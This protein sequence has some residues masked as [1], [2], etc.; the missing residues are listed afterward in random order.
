M[1]VDAS[2]GCNTLTVLRGDPDG[3]GATAAAAEWLVKVSQILNYNKGSKLEF[4]LPSKGDP[5]PLRLPQ[6][7]SPRL[8][9]VV[10]R[11]EGGGG[12]GEKKWENSNDSANMN[13]SSPLQR[14]STSPPAGPTWRS[15]TSSSAC[16][17]RPAPAPSAGRQTA[18]RW[19]SR[20]HGLA[21]AIS[22]EFFN[23]SN[24]KTSSP[25]RAAW[26]SP[27][28]GSAAPTGRQ[29]WT[30]GKPDTNILI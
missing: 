20:C 11:F 26:G 7:G 4:E 1:Y 21:D 16:A 19:T 22:I 6:P 18:T 10:L 3:V 25:A 29:A 17:G 5:A 30:S 12:A 23:F 2:P 14:R 15:R 9:S 13:N 27:T 8:H 28:Q 24:L